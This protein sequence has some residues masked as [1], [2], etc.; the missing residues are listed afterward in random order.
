MRSALVLGAGMVGVGAALALQQRGFAVALVDRRAPGEETSHGNAGIIQSEAVEPYAMPRDVP[1]LAK[2]ALGLTNDVHYRLTA[3]PGH[4]GPLARYWW[5]S[6]PNRYAAASRAYAALIAHAVPEHN[7]LIEAANVEAMVRRNGYLALHRRAETFAHAESEARRIQSEYGIPYQVLDAAAARALE[8]A[9]TG[10]ILGAVHWTGPLTVS[11][12][13][14]LVKA[15]AELFRR[16]GGT[17]VTGDAGTLTAAGKGWSVATT[18]GVLEAEIAIVA[19]GP[20]SPDL[21]RRFDYSFSMLR[22]RGY[23]RHFSGGAR[24]DLTLFDEDWGYVLAP[25]ARGLRITTGAEFTGRHAGATTVQLRRSE[26]AARALLDLGH[27]VD[28]DPWFGDR[29]VL[30]GM[31]P[32]IGAAPNHPGLWFDFGHGHQGFTLGPASGVLLAEMIAGEQPRIDP[33]PYRPFS[34]R[35]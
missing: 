15:Y 29:P 9:L 4:S 13:G 2:V 3:L 22:M 14:A 5:N 25:M 17:I 33:V 27:S 26:R 24:L 32:I 11:D 7:V 35:G 20:W 23:H 8:P 18:A 10:P 28:P 21:L 6:E 19:L 16:R 1:S 12:P 30:A 34:R 31:L